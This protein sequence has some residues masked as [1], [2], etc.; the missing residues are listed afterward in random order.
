[1]AAWARPGLVAASIA[2]AIA[3]GAVQLTPS[4]QREPAPVGLDEV[5]VGES[6]GA[7]VFAVLVGTQEP[8]VEAVLAAELPERGTEPATRGA[9]PRRDQR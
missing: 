8:D 3:V 1:L 9:I 5:L 7:A 6:G 2:L 4:G